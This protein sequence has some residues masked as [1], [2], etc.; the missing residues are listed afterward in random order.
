MFKLFFCCLFAVSAVLICPNVAAQQDDSANIH[1]Y[2]TN[3]EYEPG[4]LEVVELLQA[5]RLEHALEKADSH[6]AK[7]PKSQIGHLLRADILQSM[8][9]GLVE[10]GEQSSIPQKNLD[11]LK[12]QLRNRWIHKTFEE[13]D[14]H[15]KVPASVISMGD[16]SHVLVADMPNGRLYVY[17]NV[18]GDPHLVKDYYLTVGS[19]GYGKEVEGDNKTPV[20]VYEINDF[21]EGKKLPDLYGK[22]AFPV[23]YP[24]RFDR[25]L[26]RTG[27]G[28]W[29]HGT[30]SD[31]YARS[32]WAS[33]GCFVLSNDDLLDIG[34]YLSVE[35]KTPVVLSDAIE[36]LPLDE[37]KQRRAMYLKVLEEWRADWESLDVNALV[38]HYASKDFN[39]G[40]GNYASWL[41]R[42]RNVNKAKTFVQV[43]LKVDSLFSYPGQQDMVVVKFKQQYLSNDFASATEK[44]QYWERGSDGRWKIIYE[45]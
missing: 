7:F 43:Q 41:K 9:T 44:L 2:S 28:I 13:Q 5:G 22:G 31:T 30:P 3:G 37:L 29:L 10:V 21:I 34:Q 38:A 15:S 35:N 1:A 6:L 19:Q 32:P 45:G 12:H 27:Y 33:E 26:K 42:K 24:N 17:Q 23:N 16:H 25:Y 4:V 14:I 36:W 8:A 40:R 39:F 11:G 20:G 18:N